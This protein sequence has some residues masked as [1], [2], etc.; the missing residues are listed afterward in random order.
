M[1][2]E[3]GQV[4][5]VFDGGP[6]TRFDGNPLP[7]AHLH[8]S[9]C[10]RLLDL[11]IALPDLAAMNGTEVSG[12]LITGHSRDPARHLRLV[13]HA[14]LISFA[15]SGISRVNRPRSLKET[16]LFSTWRCPPM[17]F[18]VAKPAPDFTATAVMP[19][20]SFKADF[21]LSDYRGKYVVLFFWPL[22]FTFVC[23]SE[24]LAFD[25]ALPKFKAKNTEII[26]VSIDSQFT[27]YAWRATPV[28]QGGIGPVQFPLV[29]DLTKQISRDYGVL[30]DDAVALRG[31]FLLD[32]SR[33]RA[34]RAGQR[35]AARPQRERGPAHGR[36]PAVPRGARRRLPR[37]LAGGRRGHGADGGGRGE[38]SGE[39]QVVL[40][41][42]RPRPLAGASSF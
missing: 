15:K 6:E 11:D 30:F 28:E 34:P 3:T 27:H 8:C 38:L 18:L 26:G 22:D 23:P 17:S 36:R 5:K 2:A 32:K 25:K 40:K 9:S 19:D 37:Q 12:F 24:V 21:K 20:S 39:A 33:H 1:L 13:P 42:K 14:Q 10:E 31:L 4:V 35:P 29:A 16:S 7:H 41:K